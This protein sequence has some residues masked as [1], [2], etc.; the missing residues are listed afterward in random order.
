MNSYPEIH[1]PSSLLEIPSKTPPTP[2]SPIKPKEPIAPNKP[3]WKGSIITGI[4]FLFISF[5]FFSQIPVLNLV[6]SL[7]ITF[8]I[9]YLQQLDYKNNRK[10]F[11]TEKTRYPRLLSEFE[12]EMIKYLEEIEKLKLPENIKKY[13]EQLINNFINQ[14]Y[15]YDGVGGNAREGRYEYLLR[16]SIEKYLPGQLI[17]GTYLNIDGFPHPYSPD[18]CY[19][20]D[21]LFFDIEI[22]EPYTQTNGQYI[23]CHTNDTRRNSFFINRNWIVIRFSEKQVYCYANSCTKEIA[24]VVYQLTN[25]PIPVS[26]KSIKDLPEDKKWSTQEA[27]EMVNKRYRDSYNC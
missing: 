1:I 16:N 12:D 25:I 21:G 9:R 24:K 23:P 26:L 27:L 18:I 13:Q 10:N 8:I 4:I 20:Q 5:L 11:E 3:G 7:I 19:I 17:T 22:D 2:P 15:K 6:V 14:I